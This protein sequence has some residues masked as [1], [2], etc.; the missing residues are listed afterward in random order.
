ML[1]DVIDS[2]DLWNSQSNVTRIP[3]VH[4]ANTINRTGKLK[5]IVSPAKDRFRM[6]QRI[7]L[8]RGP[9]VWSIYSVARPCFT[10]RLP[11]YEIK[12]YRYFGAIKRV[13]PPGKGALIKVSHYW[14]RLSHEQRRNHRFLSPLVASNELNHLF[15]SIFFIHLDILKNNNKRELESEG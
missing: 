3:N 12:S 13:A 6:R 1:L 8:A 15:I 4:S 7:I 5:F 9:Y 2:S 14:F 11:A 10:H